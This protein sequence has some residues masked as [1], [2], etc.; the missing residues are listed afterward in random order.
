[1]RFFVVLFKFDVFFFFSVFK[2]FIRFLVR[3]FNLF[4]VLLLNRLFVSLKLFFVVI[5]VVVFVIYD[6]LDVIFLIRFFI[7]LGK[8]SRSFVFMSLM[9]I[10][11]MRILR[12]RFDDVLVLIL[13]FILFM[14]IKMNRML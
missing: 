14:N 9:R 5:I 6:E 11:V 13:L 3:L 12:L 7:V 4:L 8:V 2:F 10:M 1:M